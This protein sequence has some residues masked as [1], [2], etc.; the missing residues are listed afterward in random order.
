MTSHPRV[1]SRA[2]GPVDQAY[3][4]GYPPRQTLSAD[5]AA[6]LWRA[7]AESGLTNRRLSQLVGID[8][9]Y[10]SKIVR[11]SRRPSLVVAERLVEFLPLSEGEKEALFDCAV[12]DAG[13]SRTFQ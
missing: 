5:L 1:A 2:R 4:M 9:S 8:P 13:R 7:R 11:G 10:V 12:R 6:A 3:P